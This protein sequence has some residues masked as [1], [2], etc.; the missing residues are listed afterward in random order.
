MDTVS[1]IEQPLQFTRLSHWR[2]NLVNLVSALGTPKDPTHSSRFHFHLIDRFSLENAYRSDW[3][4]RRIIDAPAEDCTRNWRSWNATN[5]QIEAIELEEKRLELKK[6]VRQWIIRARLY[7]GAA[8]IIGVDDGHE[9][10]EPLDLNNVKKDSLKFVAVMNR[11]ELNAGPRI[12]NVSSRWYTRPEY[13]TVASPI[14]GFYGEPGGTLPGSMYAPLALQRGPYAPNAQGFAPK[15][16]SWKQPSW[17]SLAYERPQGQSPP[18][19]GGGQVGV[20][21]SG[22]PPGGF[23]GDPYKQ[24]SPYFGMVRLHP[25]RVMELWGNELPD[26]RLAPMGGGWGDSVLQTVDEALKDWGVTVGSIANMV[27]DAKMDVIKLPKFTERVTTA[28]YR[29]RILARFQL[30]NVSKS[31]VNSILLDTEEEWN[32]VQTSFGGIAEILRE[33]SVVVAAAGGISVSRLFGQSASRGIGAGAGGEANAQN[34]NYLDYICSYQRDVI[35]PV[36]EWLDQTLIRSTLGGPHRDV[37]YEWA[38]L[39]QLSHAEKADIAL[40]KAQ[41]FDLDV[42]QGLINEDVLRRA[43]VNQLIEDGTYPGFED[44]VDEF[45]EEP[46]IPES[47][48]WSPMLDPNTGKPIGASAGAPNGKGNGAAPP[49][50]EAKV[51]TP[52]MPAQSPELPN[53]QRVYPATHATADAAVVSKASVN[54]REGDSHRRCGLCSMFVA[55]NRCTAVLGDIH[56]EDVCDLFQPRDD[57]TSTFIPVG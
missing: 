46:D 7:G 37:D 36:M 6:K 55:P 23:G 27:N 1:T 14:F 2:D 49:Q 51:K 28:E 40:K 18:G 9:S 57:G 21:M 50:P 26:W 10:W 32:R 11:Y 25:S 47:R 8:L 42:K 45:G 31:T 35:T 15:N 19:A 43:R 38:P 34:D 33:Y 4:A 48:I 16:P 12:F 22:G 54:Y 20:R 17:T 30:A 53:L 3:I 44:A 13:Y 56:P 41:A 5:E 24:V 39:R 52:G 29:D